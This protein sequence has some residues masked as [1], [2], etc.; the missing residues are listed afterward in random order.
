MLFYRRPAVVS[1][2]LRVPKR[3]KTFQENSNRGHDE[4]LALCPLVGMHRAM[5][6]RIPYYAHPV[7][8][9]TSNRYEY[10]VTC[11]V[12]SMRLQ[13]REY[14]ACT[15]WTSYGVLELILRSLSSST[16]AH[17]NPLHVVY[18]SSEL[19]ICIPIMCWQTLRCALERASG[20]SALRAAQNRGRMSGSV[21]LPV[22]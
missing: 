13:G 5:R 22:T 18:F 9:P 2:Q 10:G 3:T 17:Y 19:A 4:C 20:P 16:R 14:D 1:Q 8:S 15:Y 21:L 7:D 12:F 11:T 6:R